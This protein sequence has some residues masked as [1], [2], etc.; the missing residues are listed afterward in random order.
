MQCFLEAEKVWAGVKFSH[1]MKTYH[2]IKQY[3]ETPYIC[4]EFCEHIS[5]KMLQT[6]IGTHIGNLF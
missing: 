4:M 1:T 5:T 3:T 2:K 6:E